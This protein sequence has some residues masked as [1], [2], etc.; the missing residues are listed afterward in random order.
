VHAVLASLPLVAGDE[1]LLTDH[2]YGSV[3]EIARFVARRTTPSCGPS[4]CPPGSLRPP[5]RRGDRRRAR[6][7]HARRGR[8]SRHLRFGARAAD[9]R[10]RRALPRRGVL[11]LADGAHAP[12]AVALDIPAVGADWYV[13]N[14]HKW[15]WAPRSSG[16]LWARPERQAELHSPVVSWGLDQGWTAEFDL[17]GTR[18]PTPHLVAPT[19]LALLHEIGLERV[20]GWNHD[21]AWRGARE[22]AERWGTRFVAPEEMVGP[23]ATVALPVSLGGT[24]EDAARLRDALLFEDGIEVHVWAR[25]GRL[26]LRFAV[27][28]YNDAGDVDRLGAAVARR[29]GLEER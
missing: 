7:A 15:A 23:M 6:S 24:R 3:I 26:G 4:I 17:P 25:G 20:L 10:D 27:Q 1:I 2:G 14:L 11:L 28:I 8:R 9:R 29:A 19:A 21:L 16:I 12:G 18:D 13:A 22:L 5:S